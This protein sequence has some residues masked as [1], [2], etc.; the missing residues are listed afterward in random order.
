MN[1]IG[2]T[3][4]PAVAGSFYPASPKELRAQVERLLAG[5]RPAAV[6]PKALIA[7]H[8]GYIYSGPIAAS[9]YATL[10]PFAARI[11]RV[12]LLGPSHF[13]PVEGLAL[14]QA[15]AFATPLGAIELDRAALTMLEGH[16]AV[17]VLDEAHQR[18]HSLEVQLPFLQVA[19][20]GFTLVPLAVGHATPE[21]TASVLDLLWGDE[22]TLIVISSDLS[23]Y[24]SYEAAA[25]VDAETARAIERLDDELLDGDHACGCHPIRGLLQVARRRGLRVVP[26]DRRSSGDTAGD[27]R[28]VVGY[29]AW[30]FS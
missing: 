13:V 24:L 28:R 22:E 9:A 2:A 11:R 21:Q 30:A 26:L 18:E 12:V 6:E 14:P 29:G 1:P 5:A 3:R 27:K 23:H 4:Q 16:P 19:L 15:G 8:A 7:P 25:V 20:P 17:C 10:A